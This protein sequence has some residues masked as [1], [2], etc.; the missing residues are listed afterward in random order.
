MDRYVVAC[1]QQR[2]RMPPTLDE[3]RE[4]A[5][6]FL[7]A[8]DTRRA[9]LVIFP[10]LGGLMLVPPLLADFRSALLIRADRGR[11]RSASLWEKI[12]GRVASSAAGMLK[13]SFH[14]GLG[15]LLDVDALRVWEQ[16]RELYGALAQEFGLTLV[17]PSAYLPDP[18]DG[19][20][21]HLTAVFG[22]DGELL[23]TQAKVM[24]GRSDEA[25]CRAGTTWDIIRTE[26]GALGVMLGNDVLYPEV[27]RLL[28]LQ[29]AEVLV[30]QGAA[31]SVAQ[32]N[33]LR[34]GVLARMQD[35]QLFA[36]CAF[37]VGPNLLQTPPGAAF[38]GKSAIFAPQ[39]LTQRQ[40][41]VLVEMGNTTSEGIVTAEWNFAEL[42]TLWATSE[43]PVWHKF[44]TPEANRQLSALY[45]HLQ[46]L[47]RPSEDLDETAGTA[48][49]EASRAE[50]PALLTLDEL[51]VIA[52]ITSRWPPGN[53]DSF[54][55]PT[56]ETLSGWT[57]LSA[58]PGQ[59]PSS[60]SAEDA[61]P[62]EEETDEMDVLP[63]AGEPSPAP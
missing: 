13:A 17:A 61:G 10:E 5:R 36:A 59:E 34:T 11:R 58:A 6:R 45:R 7:R 9:R 52:S 8:A 55:S 41:G 1:V 19:A 25:F 39:E 38:L 29:G 18:A 27:G 54:P 33:K 3:C 46:A 42:K 26:V 57:I 48:S 20:V 44:G 37:L 21:R 16:Y 24:I 15:G 14:T 22:P 56:E 49:T 35:N 43:T 53:G 2:L 23:G 50:G 62:S 60:S 32:Y 47:P 4:L 31:T 51:P 28:A 40:N 12:S 30:A 63:G